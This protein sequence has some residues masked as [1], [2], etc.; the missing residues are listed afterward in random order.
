MPYLVGYVTPQDYGA[1]GNGTTD[2]TTAIN[3][4]LSALNTAGGGTLFIPPNTF[5]ITGVLNGFSNV[6]VLGSG[7]GIS[8]IN[9]TSTS[10][11]GFTF[12]TGSGNLND[13]TIQGVTVSGPGSGT[14][15]GI[16]LEGNGGSNSVV[17]CS[18]NAVS[19]TGFGSHNI[20][21]N[22]GVGCLIETVSSASSGGHCFFINGG[23]GNSLSNCF[24]NGGANTQQGFQVTNASYTSLTGCKALACGGGYTISGGSANVISACGADTIVAANSQDGSGFKISGGTVHSI[25]GCYSN[26]NKAKAFY[27]TGSSANATINAVQEANPSGATASIQVDSGSTAISTDN[28]TVTATSYAATTTTVISGGTLTMNGPI[29]SSGNLIVGGTASL[30]DNGSGEIQLTNAT[31]VPTTNPTGGGVIYARSGSVVHRD[32]NGRVSPLVSGP[33]STG[34]TTNAL[35]ETV[36]RHSVSVV[37]TAFTSGNM[38][39]SSVFIPAGIS[40]GHIGFATGTTA[41]VTPTHWWAALLD[42]TFKQQAHS[43]DQTSTALGASTWFNLA[44]ATPFVT[45]YSGTYYLAL[46]IAAG[47]VPSILQG[48]T[49]PAAQ[50]WTGTSAPTPVP[51]GTST[52]TGL[53]TP[54]TDGTTTY[55][56]PTAAA[57]PFYLYCSV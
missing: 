50:F 49:T 4:A 55:G 56:A 40:V 42:N 23:T 35:A 9:Q 33:L 8:I 29:A 38:I 41:G 16:L 31:S 39:M 36:P 13:V 12:N 22:S 37:T 34:S 45:T 28:T 54:G 5:K 2:D 21:I 10:A 30:G 17:S 51:G 15:V 25:V 7:A 48:S 26:I 14:G 53:T 47:T 11:N 32:P 1:A 46:V 3:N 18:L 44:M 57:A 6:S 27:V 43:A 20:Q 19:V 24:A 52:T